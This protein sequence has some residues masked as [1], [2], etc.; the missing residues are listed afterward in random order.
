MQIIMRSVCKKSEK[1][2]HRDI[3]VHVMKASG[4]AD[5]YL[6]PS[7][8]LVNRWKW[9]ISFILFIFTHRTPCRL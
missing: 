1:L 3:S 5:I 7:L 8:S 2:R 9:V 4:G 6:H